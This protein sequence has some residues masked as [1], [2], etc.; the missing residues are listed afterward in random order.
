[1]NPLLNLLLL[2]LHLI[3]IYVQCLSVCFCLLHCKTT[4]CV[5]VCVFVRSVSSEPLH[6]YFLQNSA[7]GCRCLFSLEAFSLEQRIRVSLC[8]HDNIQLQL[9]AMELGHAHQVQHHRK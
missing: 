4:V 5:C 6:I 3:C 2:D 8:L 7:S 1:M 9:V